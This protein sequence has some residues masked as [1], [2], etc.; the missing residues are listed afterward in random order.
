MIRL[1]QWC[2]K[3]II[4]PAIPA[5]ARKWRTQKYHP[6]PYRCR[7]EAYL[8]VH[9]KRIR[10][11][12]RKYKRRRYATNAAKKF[13][14]LPTLTRKKGIGSTA[15]AR[16]VSVHVGPRRK[17]VSPES[18]V[19]LTERE[20]LLGNLLVLSAT[21]QEMVEK[22]WTGQIGSCARQKFARGTRVCVEGV[23]SLTISR[24]LGMP[25]TLSGDPKG[26]TIQFL[27]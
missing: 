6:D 9:G 1:C 17:R 24:S 19:M 27:I 20:L 5:R 11:W 15:S 10:E 22:Y 23:Q 7:F 16:S 18:S 3:E 26:G 13:V 4:K 25:I 12:H 14:Y 8:E 21:S 2:A